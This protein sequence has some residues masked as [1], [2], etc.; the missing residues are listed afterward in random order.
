[1]DY[2]ASAHG[3]LTPA[4]VVHRHIVDGQVITENLYRYEPFKMFSADTEISSP[5][6]TRRPR[7]AG[8]PHQ[9]NEPHLLPPRLRLIPTVRPLHT[10]RNC[11]RS[12]ACGFKPSAEHAKRAESARKTDR[13]EIDSN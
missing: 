1:M 3:F 2:I 6:W 7:P 10:T 13:Q 8:S 4:S 5:S 11:K 12:R 9:E